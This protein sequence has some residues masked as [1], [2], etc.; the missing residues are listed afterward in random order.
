M[1]VPRPLQAVM[2]GAGVGA[3]RRSQWGYTIRP[4]SDRR[5]E[6]T[7]QTTY[8]NR[9]SLK[10]YDDLWGDFVFDDFHRSVLRLIRHRAERRS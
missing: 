5:S 8:A 9:S 3:V 4:L 1:G 6:V 7:L 2:S 10:L